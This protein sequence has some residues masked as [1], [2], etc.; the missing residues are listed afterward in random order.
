M[1][2]VSVTNPVSQSSSEM[3]F[4]LQELC[5]DICP[6]SSLANGCI[7]LSHMVN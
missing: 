7:G 2:Y 6:E 5:L 4:F 1:G 3:F